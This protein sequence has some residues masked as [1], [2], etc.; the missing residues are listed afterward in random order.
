MGP[1]FNLDIIIFFSFFFIFCKRRDDHW[2]LNSQVVW[3][4]GSAK[5]Q[6]MRGSLSSFKNKLLRN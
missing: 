2:I 5:K 3:L 4:T 6:T 1:K